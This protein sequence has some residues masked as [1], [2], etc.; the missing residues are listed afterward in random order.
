MTALT[1]KPDAPSGEGTQRLEGRLRAMT[2]T[3]IVLAVAL[4]GLGAWLIYDQVADSETAPTGEV[5]ALLDD[6]NSAWNAYDSDAFLG[7]VTESYTFE[8][9][10]DVNTAQEQADEIATLGQVDWHVDMVGK[11]I[12]SGNGDPNYYLAVPNSITSNVG[13][14]EGMSL[15]VVVGDGDTFRIAQHTFVGD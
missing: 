10:G 5:A 12:M 9:A 14:G 4:I 15:F 2:I 3:V 6:Y 11:P 1:E 8:Y 7:L 13:D